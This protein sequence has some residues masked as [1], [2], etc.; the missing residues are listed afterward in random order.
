MNG[1]RAVTK[2]KKIAPNAAQEIIEKMTKAQ[3]TKF[4]E[5]NANPHFE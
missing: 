3:T 1:Y 4:E 2:Y 5:A